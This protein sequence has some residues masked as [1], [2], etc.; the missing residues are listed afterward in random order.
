M[1]IHL[2]FEPISSF[3]LSRFLPKNRLMTIECR[4]S[5][6]A[7]PI[8]FETWTSY[9][10]DY[11]HCRISIRGSNGKISKKVSNRWKWATNRSCAYNK[12]LAI[13]TLFS[14]GHSSSSSKN[15]KTVKKSMV[16][17]R[18]IFAINSDQWPCS[19]R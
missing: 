2:R 13:H 17:Y 16:N 6:W 5:F 3:F 19:Q 8:Y 10:Q 1:E 18:I 12:C 14:G 15:P 9:L 7:T 11:L 4:I